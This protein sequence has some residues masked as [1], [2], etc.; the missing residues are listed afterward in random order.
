M[1][2]IYL[3]ETAALSHEITMSFPLLVVDVRRLRHELFGSTVGNAHVN[4]L[5]LRMLPVGDTIELI[6]FTF[7]LLWNQP[8]NTEMSYLIINKLHCLF[9]LIVE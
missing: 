8:N 6:S 2:F 7:A 4:D 1:F 3:L 9:E 5:K